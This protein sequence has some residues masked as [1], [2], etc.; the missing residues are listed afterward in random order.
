MVELMIVWRL[1]EWMI[2]NRKSKNVNI[3]GQITGFYISRICFVF[4]FFVFKCYF[5]CSATFD[6]CISYRISNFSLCLEC[7]VCG[8]NRTLKIIKRLTSI[9]FW[10]SKYIHC[11]NIF[12]ARSAYRIGKPKKNFESLQKLT[13]FA[14]T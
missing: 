13:K 12:K 1:I 2:L 5:R 8:I 14:G 10:I 9:L 7:Y 6:E 4:F 3:D 11:S